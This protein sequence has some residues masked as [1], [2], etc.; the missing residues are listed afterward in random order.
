MDCRGASIDTQVL[1]AVL[2]GADYAA[3][4]RAM[5]DYKDVA[6]GAAGLLGGDAKRPATPPTAPSSPRDAKDGEAKPSHARR[7]DAKGAK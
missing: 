3:F 7:D 1:R 5:A 2:A 6:A 4:V